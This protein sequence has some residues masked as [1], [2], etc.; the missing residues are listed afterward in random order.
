MTEAPAPASDAPMRRVLVIGSGG[1]GKSTL[2]TWIAERTGLPLVH[3]DACYW[4]AGWVPTPAD[5]WAA[6]VAR[7]TSADAWVMDGNYGGT[8]DARLAACDT[9]I[10]LDFPRLVCLA[11]VVRR[12]LRYRG[13]SRP[14]LTPGCPEQLSWEFVS[15]IWSYPRRRRPGILARLGALA[16][17]KRVVILRSRREAARW[18][19]ELAQDSESRAV[20]ARLD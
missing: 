20:G 6:T 10:F 14:D 5:E 18:L 1:A 15:W 2:A 8:L 13:R 19:D 17:E 12:W 7:L 11:S 3:L 9:V 4:R 16:G